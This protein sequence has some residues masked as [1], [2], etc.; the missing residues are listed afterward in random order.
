[1]PRI[2]IKRG[3]T[4]QW[5]AS[6]TPLLS[7]EL[8]YDL[9]TK[10]IKIGDGTTLWASLPS[11]DSDGGAD[12]GDVT[13]NGVRV[14]GA[15]TGSGDGY[16]LGTLELVPDGDITSDQYLIIDPTAPNH[17]HIRGGG[18]QDASGADLFIGGER[19]NVRVSDGG[20]SVSISTRP[21]TVINTYTNL[22]ET[23]NTSFV[24]SNTA[25]IYIGDT[26]FYVGG[27]IVTVD[28]ITQDLPSAGLQTITANLNGAPASFVAGEPHIFSHEEEWE[29]YWQFGA[30]GV[31]S[32]PGGGTLI[33]SG[34]S[35]EPGDDVFAIVADQNLVLQHGVGG[36]YLND[37]TIANNHI[38]TMGDITAANEYTDDAIAG[39]VNAIP[40]SYVPLSDVGVADGVA[41]LDENGKIPDSE[42]PDGIAR[43]SELFSGSYDDLSNKP[44]IALGAVQWTANHYLLPGGENTRYLAGDIV[45]D[46]GNIYVA[47]F[48][49]ESL[50]TT[51]TEYWSLIGSGKRLNI[52]GR[53][54]PNITYD[55]LNGKPTIPDLTGY[56][57]ETYVGTAISNL[58]DTAPETLN[59]L[60]ELAAAL[61]DDPN[62]ATT[63]STSLGNK[64]DS[65]TASSTYAPIANPTFTGTVGGITKSMVGL[66]NVDNTTDAN[67][68]VS[69]AT[70]TVL[71]LKAPLASPTF[72]GTVSGITKS[73]VGLENVDNTSDAN[74]PVS[75]ATQTALDAKSNIL[76]TTNAQSSNYTIDSADAGKLIEMSSGGTLTIT[77]SSLFPVGFTC[78]VLQTGSSQVT[79]AGSGF[80][81]NATPGLKLRAQWSSATLI[82]RALNS[83]VVLGDLS[84]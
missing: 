57:T 18:T 76:V 83:W 25:N 39:L 50:P 77:D 58:V 21:E 20:R 75:T 52:D 51:S 23:S 82:K 44:N 35:G 48:D 65:S 6:T 7:G 13:F 14:I 62:F 36:A 4:T 31:L 81:P 10:V 59:T 80:T 70:Q 60:N 55:Q 34:I 71:N 46:G 1:M 8:G 24:T 26:L 79:I 61:G 54:I 17:I 69:T 40:E 47:N 78:D 12:T 73:M 68:P 2:R 27:D 32:G 72:T 33:V 67:K 74:K 41:S 19:N 49:N 11:I 29:N 84:V 16:G 63:I 64:L 28:S 37:S 66:A 3:T 9:T 5:I 38:A 15:G 45:Y 43:D 53:D 30:D 42:I 56:A 22:N